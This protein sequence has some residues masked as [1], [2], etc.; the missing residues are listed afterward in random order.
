MEDIL[1]KLSYA[2]ANTM[3][4]IG[5]LSLLAIILMTVASVIGRAL[6]PIGLGPVPGDYEIT[7][8]TIAFVIF[9]FLPLCQLVAGHATVDVFTSGMGQRTNLILL[10]IWEVLLTATMIFIAWRLYEGFLDKLT[11]N[12][13]SM[14]LAIPVWWGYFAALFPAC[15]GVIV[16]L[17]SAYDR[18]SAA[19]TG[20]VTRTIEGANH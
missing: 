5:G 11:N 8:M 12:E 16:G 1:K 10:A 4:M 6:V 15:V 17:W 18:A 7:E 20:K 19:L 2:L 9:C 14:L 13:I 3:A